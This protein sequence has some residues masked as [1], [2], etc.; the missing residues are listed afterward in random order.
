MILSILKI[1]QLS[2]KY[3]LTIKNLI[4]E[5][6]LLV[7]LHE[8]Y[9]VFIEFHL[10]TYIASIYMPK[11]VLIDLELKREGCFRLLINLL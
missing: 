11:A 3:L 4:K 6:Q 10:I 9:S 2:Y 7:Y 5:C 8:V 1:S